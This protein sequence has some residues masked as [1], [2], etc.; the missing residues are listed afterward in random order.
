MPVPMYKNLTDSD[1]AAICT[2]QVDSGRQK[3]RSGA[4]PARA[5]PASVGS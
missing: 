1:L 5:G 4:A 3:P 2:Y